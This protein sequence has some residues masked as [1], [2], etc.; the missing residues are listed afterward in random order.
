MSAVIVPFPG[1]R[2]AP[3][4]SRQQVQRF[5]AE[6]QAIAISIQNACDNLGML[7]TTGEVNEASFRAAADALEEALFH[8]LTMCGCPEETR[9]LRNLLNSLRQL[10]DSRQ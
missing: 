4:A 2:T 1:A 7:S 6:L 8:T 3:S 5:H 10:R 9:P